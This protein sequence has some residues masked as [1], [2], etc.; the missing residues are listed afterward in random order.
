MCKY[1]LLITIIFSYIIISTSVN[2][3][4]TASN[5]LRNLNQ[6]NTQNEDSIS[7]TTPV[8]T[9]DITECQIS[10]GNIHLNKQLKINT[11]KNKGT[12]YPNGIVISISPTDNPLKC[13]EKC[14]SNTD[15]KSWH[16]MKDLGL[17]FINKNIPARVED[18]RYDSG[19]QA[20]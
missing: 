7:S 11:N 6:Q 5:H 3:L 17:C 10:E 20:K 9:G 19:L 15:C 12:S 18:S 14:Q 2:S 8:D 1:I 16:R 13:C 4:G